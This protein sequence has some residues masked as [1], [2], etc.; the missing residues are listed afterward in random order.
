[1]A[2]KLIF[3]AKRIGLIFWG[4]PAVL[5]MPY[6]LGFR[7]MGGA[8]FEETYL[9]WQLFLTKHFSSGEFPLW[10]P[11]A[12]LG[13][14][15]WAEVQNALLYPPRW[16][17]FWDP[18]Y[19]IALFWVIHLAVAHFGVYRLGR[20]IGISSFSAWL[21]GAIF[22]FCGW[23]AGHLNAN[24]CF[25]VAAVSWTPLLL[26][27]WLTWPKASSGARWSVK[28]FVLLSLILQAGSPQLAY[29]SLFFVGVAG[30]ILY[31]R[32]DK[33]RQ[34][35]AWTALALLCAIASAL[36]HGWALYEFGQLSTRAGPYPWEKA[37]VLALQFQDIGQIVF[38]PSLEIFSLP[39]VR[40]FETSI[41][42]GP[43]TLG[44][45]ILAI[46]GRRRYAWRFLG[47]AVLFLSLAMAYPGWLLEL[48]RFLP[49][50][51]SFRVPGR[52]LV[53]SLLSLSLLAGLGVDAAKELAER[54][55][56]KPAMAILL[57][58]LGLTALLPLLAH[59]LSCL[60]DASEGSDELRS[61]IVQAIADEQPVGRPR[62]TLGYGPL[63]PNAFWQ[64][65][66]E[67]IGGRNTLYPW[68]YHRYVS[69]ILGTVRHSFM[70][71]NYLPSP[72]RQSSPLSLAAAP[73]FIS[74]RAPGAMK[75]MLLRK[76]VSPY[77]LYGDGSAVSRAR[78][79]AKGKPFP[80]R[81]TSYA[82][83]RS[84][85]NPGEELIY[86]GPPVAQSDEGARG[87][88]RFEAPSTDHVTIHCNTTGPGWVWISQTY[89]PGWQATVNDKTAQI[90]PAHLLFQTVRIPTGK[91]EVRLRYLPKFFLPS[92]FICLLALGMQ[93]LLWFGS[94]KYL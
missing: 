82:W 57:S 41:Y 32:T 71:Q 48:F 7:R 33:A 69:A 35:I 51:S 93:A 16:I 8:D 70:V 10:N 83:L 18:A 94:K 78:F 1:M 23:M 21:A 20:T 27:H 6:L 11:F 53:F 15:V 86:E 88:C 45:G 25:L 61:K 80:D 34:R 91:S 24:H 38:G 52:F 92:L 60:P 62:A 89:D 85:K 67:M 58:G 31:R 4:L 9:P 59:T 14:P 19:T 47:L 74:L 17:L 65:G 66:V 84:T 5:F 30:T 3:A 90:Y 81:E 46:V 12:M 72:P 63:F 28:L 68:R 55:I 64:D 36:P 13:T 37:I 22:A 26:N 49:G 56:K 87:A 29:Y 73:T 79:Y 2:L 40:F 75:P 43:V 42:L 76:R 39:S 44:L 77:Y 50:T 54:W